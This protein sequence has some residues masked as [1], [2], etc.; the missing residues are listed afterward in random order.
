MQIVRRSVHGDEK[1]KARALVIAAAARLIAP[2]AG[3][4]TNEQD[5]AAHHPRA[6]QPAEK[7]AASDRPSQGQAD[8]GR[9]MQENMQ[10]M[11]KLMARA[12]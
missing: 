7:E 6:A 12:Q 4:Q 9:R 11:S 8:M 1:K 3:A 5:P 10:K 2:A